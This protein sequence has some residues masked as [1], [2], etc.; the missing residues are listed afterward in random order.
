ML[1]KAYGLDDLVLLGQ[2]WPGFNIYFLS[3]WARWWRGAVRTGSWRSRYSA[4][5]IWGTLAIWTQLSGVNPHHKHTSKLL[6]P[7]RIPKLVGDAG[8]ITK[9]PSVLRWLLLMSC[10]LP[11]PHNVFHFSPSH[12]LTLQSSDLLFVKW[13]L[14]WRII[15][16]IITATTHGCIIDSLLNWTLD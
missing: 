15:S 1:A 9:P 7:R 2:C 12:F 11:Q 13:I 16:E 4:L 8:L 5:T 3:D 10:P 14:S 6:P